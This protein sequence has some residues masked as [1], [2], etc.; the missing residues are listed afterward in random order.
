MRFTLASA[1][2]VLSFGSLAVAAPNTGSSQLSLVSDPRSCGTPTARNEHAEQLVRP[3][4]AAI[5]AARASGLLSSSKVTNVPVVYHIIQKGSSLLEGN[6]SAEAV[7]GQIKALNDQY[8]G[9]GFSFTLAEITHTLNADWFSNAGP[10]TTQQDDMKAA[11]RQGGS[12]TLNLYSVGFEA[13]AGAGLLGYATFPFT[14][15]VA[16]HDDGVVFRYS[17]VPGGS[18]KNYDLGMTVTHEAGHWLG[19]FHTFQGGCAD[20]DANLDTAPEASPASGCPIGRDTCP[21]IDVDP[22]HNYMDYD[23]CM[24]GFTPGQADRMSAMSQLFRT[25]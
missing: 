24:T 16:P 13:G 18:T 5:Q 1:A 7:D 17:S 10:S 22:I 12:E 9:F 23:A 11:L 20:G 25:N 4:I 2:A 14:Y 15:P 19:L 21:G 8:A 6:V 3:R